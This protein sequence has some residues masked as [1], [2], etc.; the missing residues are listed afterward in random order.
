M[1]KL[2]FGSLLFSLILNANAQIKFGIKTGFNFSNMAF[3]E[4]IGMQPSTSD[5]LGYHIGGIFDLPLFNFCSIQPGI[6]FTTKGFQ[7][8]DYTVTLDYFEVPVNLMLKIGSPKVKFIIY[9]GY[10]VAAGISGIETGNSANDYTSTLK[11]SFGSASNDLTTIDYGINFGTGFEVKRIQIF[12]QYGYSRKNLSND[13]GESI[14]NNVFSLSFIYL[15]YLGHPKNIS[16]L[17]M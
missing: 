11:L 4:S 8:N 6:L 3:T 16:D 17:Y 1:K 13:K 15:F 14:N 7:T 10:Y 9:G 2:L 5:C 12:A